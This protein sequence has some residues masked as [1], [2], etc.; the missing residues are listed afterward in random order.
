MAKV[1]DCLDYLERHDY[2]HLFDAECRKRWENIRGRFGDLETEETILEVNLVREAPGCDYSIRLPRETAY[3]Q[4]YWL[5]LDYEACAGT[6]IAPC[7]F[8]DALKATDT[9]A[10][11]GMAEELLPE[12][13]DR[14]TVET[15]RPL[16]LRS[17]EAAFARG[18][19]IFQIGSMQGRRPGV[20]LRVFLDDLSPEDILSALEELD[21]CGDMPALGNLL[22]MFAPYSD[23]QKF[24]IDFDI[25]PEGLSQKI[26]I[27]FG[28]RDKRTATVAHLL[29]FLQEKGLCLPAKRA[30]VLRFVD[31]FPSY[32]PYLQNDISHFKLAFENSQVTAAKAYLRQGTVPYRH[33]FRA[34]E[35]PVL[36]N[37]ELTTRCPLRCP[38]CYCNLKGGYD[39]E[40]DTA[41]YWIREAAKN[42]VKVMNLS[43]GETLLYPH[44]GELIAECK[45]LGMEAN[46]A[47][48]GYGA[49]KE[50]LSSLIARGTADICVSLNGSTDEI[51]TLSRDGYQMAV[52]ALEN[53]R[54]LGYERTVIN[55]VMHSFNAEDFPNIIRLAEEYAVRGIAI[56]MFKPDRHGAMDSVPQYDQVMTLARQ[57]KEYK[58][59]VTLTVEECFSQLRAV[60]GQRFFVNT[61]AGIDRGCG[62]GRDGVSVSVDGSLTPCRHL[63]RHKEKWECLADYWR[64][65]ATLEELRRVEEQKG[66]TCGSCRYRIYCLPCQAVSW[67]L[68]GTFAM[69]AYGC[70][71]SDG[72]KRLCVK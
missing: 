16:L 15:L 56:I 66:D 2:A 58:G 71:I 3:S 20:S 42:G 27:N 10:I 12:I 35:S 55:W 19:K 50:T 17:A 4:E 31:D 53:L 49:D 6:N 11:E 30:D 51:N 70:P 57:I 48:S 36:M 41:L 60:L 37:L 23:R 21:W 18:G 14:G 52:N 39:M 64:K 67:E 47:I 13:A 44:L 40:L 38:Q 54:D 1:R 32:S 46:I 43:G 5:E 45:H 63:F 9:A 72:E 68:A 61:N 8:F 28:T 29:G 69:G 33:D 62:A 24:I 26:G 34:Y 22:E 7:Y 59:S 65:S 25:S